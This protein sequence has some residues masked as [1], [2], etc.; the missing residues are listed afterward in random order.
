M[1]IFRYPK[2]LLKGIY[3]IS[4]ILQAQIQFIAAEQAFALRSENL[5]ISHWIKLREECGQ[6]GRTEPRD[7]ICNIF[8]RRSVY[9]IEITGAIG[10]VDVLAP[11]YH[12]CVHYYFAVCNLPEYLREFKNRHNFTVDHIAE[13]V[14]RSDRRKLIDIAYEYQIN[15]ARNGIGG[16]PPGR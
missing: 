7:H 5:N 15:A 11:I 4:D 8:F 14:A 6:S 10:A 12:M 2:I 1:F 3:S 9:E 16:F 13:S